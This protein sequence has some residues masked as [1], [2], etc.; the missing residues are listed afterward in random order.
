MKIALT[1]GG[2]EMIFSEDELTKILEEHFTSQEEQQTIPKPKEGECFEVNPSSIKKELFDKCLDN[3]K[4]EKTRMIILEAFDKLEEQPQK[5]GKT[6]KTFMPMKTWDSM[7]PNEQIELASKLGDHIADWVEQALEWAQ[8]IT[9]GESWESIC[10]EPDSANYFRFFIGKK[11]LP[12]IVG[13]A[14]KYKDDSPASYVVEYGFVSSS[15][16]DELAVPLVVIYDN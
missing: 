10:N 9:N 2:R 5:Y 3:P 12:Q 14:C 4:Q 7:S 15:I 6:F 8:R 11:G 16:V 13:G 1:I